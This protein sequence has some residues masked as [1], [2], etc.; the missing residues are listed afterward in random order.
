MTMREHKGSVS[1]YHFET[2]DKLPYSLSSN[3]RYNFD[4]LVWSWVL[5][6]C[7]LP[8][9]MVVHAFPSPNPTPAETPSNV[10]M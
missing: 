4:R 5:F 9:Q 10:D 7:V 1:R 3:M 6:A 2:S 8:Y